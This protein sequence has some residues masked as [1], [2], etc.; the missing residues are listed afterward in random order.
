[1]LVLTR[2][3]REAI[4]IG[5]DIEI[6]VLAIKDDT[7]RLK[8]DCP[9]M[10]PPAREETLRLDNLLSINGKV[11]VRVVSIRPEGGRV[12]LGVN[13]PRSIPIAREEVGQHYSKGRGSR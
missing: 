3:P 10:D 13:A 7:V 12:R 4:L 2:L 1:M 9:R 5:D 11:E 6:T 8:I